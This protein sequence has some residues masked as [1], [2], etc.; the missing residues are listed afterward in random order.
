MTTQSVV[1]DL[2]QRQ[3]WQ[4]WITVAVLL[5]FGSVA[6]YMLSV[7]T[8]ANPEV[9]QRR[10]YVFSGVQAIAFTAVGWLFGREV[11][12]GARAEARQATV[13][14]AEARGKEKAVLT[15]VGVIAQ[16]QAA[17]EDAQRGFD[18]AADATGVQRIQQAIEEIYNK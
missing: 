17:G 6:V 2:P 3:W 12:S 16:Q 1:E 18:K 11:N 10:V 5:A 4:L 7:A 13:A 14:L 15:A 9:W 8:D